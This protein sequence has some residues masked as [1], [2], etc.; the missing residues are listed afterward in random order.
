MPDDGVAV[1]N[2]R[3]GKNPCQRAAFCRGRIAGAEEKFSHDELAFFNLD[4]SDKLLYCAEYRRQNVVYNELH[5]GRNRPAY[6]TV[7]SKNYGR[8]RFRTS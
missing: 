8:E 2:A 1:R 3:C 6:L 7:R 5:A 4:Y